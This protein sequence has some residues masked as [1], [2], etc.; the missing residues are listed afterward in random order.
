MSFNRVIPILMENKIETF[1][2]KLKRLSAHFSRIQVDIIDGKFVENQTL[3][4]EKLVAVEG[5]AKIEAEAHLMV[6]DPIAYLP[7]CRQAGFDRVIAQIE[8]M[9]DQAHFVQT[10]RDLDL[11][12]GL[13]L[14]LD[15]EVEMIF[16]GLITGVKTVLLMSVETGFSG[17]EFDSQALEKIKYLK[18]LAQGET[19]IE[20]DGGINDKTIG[21]VFKAGADKVAVNSFLWQGKSLEAQMEKLKKSARDET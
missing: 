2:K 16:P 4:L 15:T 17:Q 19:E 11:K 12:P 13:A 7:R 21:Q 5:L 3:P 8:M 10:C 6:A 18:E 1:E 20:V 14:S 9:R